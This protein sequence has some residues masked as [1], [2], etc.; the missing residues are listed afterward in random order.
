[1]TFTPAVQTGR[2]DHVFFST[3][4]VAMAVVV[5]AGF[6]RPYPLRIAAGTLSPLAHLHGVVFALWMI[7]FIGGNFGIV[8]AF[9]FR[10]HPVLDVVAGNFSYRF[11]DARA[12][13]HF[14]REFM[15]DAPD[16]FQAD[17]T[18]VARA[19]VEATV[20]NVSSRPE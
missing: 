20:L 8:T 5:G 18:V 10:L 16:E 1:M 4:S 11:E 9:E 14:F 19:S 15:A 3:M 13:L 12:V 6:S 7:L 2:W 17:L